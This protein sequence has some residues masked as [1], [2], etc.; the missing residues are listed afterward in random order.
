MIVKSNYTTK[1]AL[2]K[3]VTGLLIVSCS[4]AVPESET[5]KTAAKI[6]IDATHSAIEV[7]L[8]PDSEK[9]SLMIVYPEI[10][11]E[12]AAE[13]DQTKLTQMDING[14]ITEEISYSKTKHY[15]KPEGVQDSELSKIDATKIRSINVLKISAAEID[16]LKVVDPE[17]FGDATVAN[18]QKTVFT[19]TDESGNLASRAEFTQKP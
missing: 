15:T 2:L 6:L 19:Y 18:Y 4:S 12:R 16:S 5:Q 17:K 11:D 10:F 1:V 13:Y 8:V 3:A 7:T 14:K 9:D